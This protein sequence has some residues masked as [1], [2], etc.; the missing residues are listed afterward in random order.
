M[1]NMVCT[2]CTCI[3]VQKCSKCRARKRTPTTQKCWMVPQNPMKD[4]HV[5]IIIVTSGYSPLLD[6]PIFVIVKSHFQPCNLK[7][8]FTS[9][10]HVQ[11]AYSSI[12]PSSWWV[13]M[14]IFSFFNPIIK[15]LLDL[16]IVNEYHL[17][18]Y[19]SCS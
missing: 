9:L 13:L 1:F 6:K 7:I 5:P 8:D 14:R 16:T 10:N 12:F 18:E 11:S 3:M 4:H 17:R 19:V 15:S 2:L